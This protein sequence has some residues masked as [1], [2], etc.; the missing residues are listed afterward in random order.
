[1]TVEI[2][3][4]HRYLTDT[5]PTTTTDMTDDTDI[6]DL[7]RE[8]L[9][10]EIAANSNINLDQ[11]VREWTGE[12]YVE[13]DSGDSTDDY[14]LGDGLRRTLALVTEDRNDTH[15]DPLD[16]HAQIAGLWSAF[17]QFKLDEAIEPWEAA[18]MMQHVKQSRMQAG[19]LIADHFDDIAGY[20]EVGRYCAI[21]DEGV[22]VEVPDE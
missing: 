12:I 10:D 2:P 11:Y 3:C 9:I 8:E 16:N 1:M 17:L 15:G 19:S 22:D 7:D 14:E 6:D 18:I 5:D 13:S 4:T 21:R 20:A